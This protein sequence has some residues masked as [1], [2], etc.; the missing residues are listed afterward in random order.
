MLYRRNK[1]R[2]WL[3]AITVMIVGFM[4]G[5]CIGGLGTIKSESLVNKVVYLNN[6]I[7]SQNIVMDKLISRIGNLEK[8][9]TVL[10]KKISIVSSDNTQIKQVIGAITQL[11]GQLINKIRVLEGNRGKLNI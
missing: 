9:N 10:E 5:I 4:L 7:D 11:I 2:S 1:M 3:I 8:R 6:S